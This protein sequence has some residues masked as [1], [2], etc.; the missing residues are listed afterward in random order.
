MPALIVIGLW[1]TFVIG[2]IINLVDVIQ[3]AIAESP[4]TTFFIVKC[5][6]VF[7]APLGSII[8]LF[9]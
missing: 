4:V 3:L 9:F 1:L 2:W 7:F 8:G 5:V 6:G